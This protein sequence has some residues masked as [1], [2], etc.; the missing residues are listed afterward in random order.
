M[1]R[2]NET[3]AIWSKFCKSHYFQ[4]V[5]NEMEAEML[6][7][8]EEIERQ[9]R[10]IHELQLENSHPRWRVKDIY[11]NSVD[12]VSICKK[13]VFGGISCMI[14][15][16]KYNF[17]CTNTN[18][19][20]HKWTCKSC[21]QTTRKETIERYETCKKCS[22][23]MEELE[24]YKTDI[25]SKEQIIEI[26]MEDIRDLKDRLYARW[27]IETLRI[28]MALIKLCQFLIR[29]VSQLV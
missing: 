3:N 4:T 23:L 2:K 27:R 22:V 5:V 7:R 14:C 24:E 29:I 8:Q 13:K 16:S 11:K 28:L 26:L 20:I 21:A 19:E 6:E 1:E 12:K 25:A 17:S 15:S 18:K 9:D 10:V